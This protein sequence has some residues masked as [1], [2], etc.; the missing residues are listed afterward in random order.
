MTRNI[1]KWEWLHM[2][3]GQENLSGHVRRDV[4]DRRTAPKFLQ[5]CDILR[6]RIRADVFLDGKSLPSVNQLSQEF[7]VSRMTVFKALDELEEEGLV[8][9]EAGRGV[10]VS[11]DAVKKKIALDESLGG[12]RE[13]RLEAM[14]CI[15]G[16]LPSPFQNDIESGSYQYLKR[17][18]LTDSTPYHLGHYYIPKSIADR[19]DVSVWKEKTVARILATSSHYGPVKVHQSISMD[20]AEFEVAE[21]LCI[22]LNAPVFQV[23]RRFVHASS[24][25]LLALAQ[26]IFRSDL[27]HFETTFGLDSI[28]DI[29]GMRGKLLKG[30]GD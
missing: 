7:G 10:F 19:Y 4:L 13:S 12:L 11:Q 28:E 27:V 22:A 25:E 9:R 30:Q 5:I 17:I 26:L 21:D 18:M 6:R 15:E 24:E 1:K 14:G 3:K 2:A 23:I 20:T 16:K 29:S 8:W